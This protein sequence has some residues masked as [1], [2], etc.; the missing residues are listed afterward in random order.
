MKVLVLADAHANR[1]ALDAIDQ[2]EKNYD[3]V[4]FAGDHVD[5]GMQPE[6][7]IQWMRERDTISVR[8]NHD[9]HVLG[10][11]ENDCDQA[12]KECRFTWAHLCRMRLSEDSMNYLH[13]LPVT[14]IITID[15]ICYQMQHMYRDN[16]DTIQNVYQF[17]R[18]WKAD[19]LL[20]RRMIFGHSHRRC[21]HQLDEDI[22]WLNPGSVSYRRGDDP[23]K[24]A[25]YMVIQDGCIRFGSVEYDARPYLR[26]TAYWQIKHIMKP[27]EL[28]NAYF[29]FS[30]APR[31]HEELP[32][33]AEAMD[34]LGRLD[35]E[36]KGSS[37]Q[38][39]L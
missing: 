18:F 22:C 14:R 17:E 25:H 7:V 39:F 2:K 23:D 38:G 27:I 6:Q 12:I 13:S 3:M 5:Y 19:K 1:L 31:V 34:M 10:L 24:N 21:V 16:Y 20:K 33:D 29:F 35:N 8:G 30:T 37:V 32:T 26:E 28:L 4:L 11:R 36:I 9:D 15:S